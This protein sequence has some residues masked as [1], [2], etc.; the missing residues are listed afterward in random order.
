MA[1]TFLPR[2]ESLFLQWLE[3]F[4]AKLAEYVALFGLSG[5]QV[6]QF[7][8][9]RDSVKNNLTEV[10]SLKKTLQSK[11]K[12]KDEV[13]ALARKH[14]QDLAG[15]LKR[16]PSYT[17]AI[18]E[19]L[20]IVAPETPGAGSL[21]NAKPK[22]FATTLVDCAR[23]DW[24]KEK[25]DGV[26]VY[27]KRGAETEYTKLDEDYRSPMEDKRKNLVAGVPELRS[28]KARF[29]KDDV[30]VGLWSDEVTVTV[31]IS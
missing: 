9:D 3:N 22:I 19:N 6:D 17:E 18:G 25:S 1:S 29:L 14:V 5:G 10:D 11:V 12:T 30:E 26:V 16:H 28:Y 8:T 13:V 15:I 31:L 4:I 20:G 7:T 27:S 23:L 24:L 2:S 21:E